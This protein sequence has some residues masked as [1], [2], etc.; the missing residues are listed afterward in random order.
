MIVAQL[1]EWL[2]PIPEVG[3]LN[4]VVGTKFYSKLIP[5]SWVDESIEN[6]PFYKKFLQ[7][8]FDCG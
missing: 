3:G 1:A 2:I 6:V 8:I 7:M 4:P 5:N